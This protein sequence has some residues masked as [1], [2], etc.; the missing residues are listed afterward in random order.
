MRE[1]LDFDLEIREGGPEKYPIS[2]DSPGGQALEEMRFPFD[3]SELKNKLLALENALLRSG[4]SH[5]SISP[6]EQT[7]REFGERLFKAVLTGDVKTRYEVSLREARQQKKGLRLKLR[8]HPPKL[9]LLPWE[10]LYDPDSGEY[11]CF[12]SNTPLVRYVDLRRPVEQLPV[13]PPLKILGMVASPTDLPQLDV[14]K[15]KGHV[16]EALEI[17]RE[18]GLV[19]L[20]WLEEQTWSALL[21]AMWG[22]PWHI[23]HF[24]GHGDFDRNSG[25]GRVAFSDEADRQIVLPARKLARLLDDHPD[26]RLAFLNSCEGAKGGEGDPFSGTAATLVRRGVPAVVA[27]QYEI[28]DKAAIEFSRA[29]YHA[30]ASNLPVDAAVAAARTAVSMYDTL[31]W[32]TPVLYMRSPDGCLFDIKKA[33]GE[34]D[35][36]LRQYR[37]AVET[38]WTSGELHEREVQELEK[39]AHKLGLPPTTAADIEREIMGETKEESLKRRRRAAKEQYRKAVEAVWA[40]DELS[41]AEVEWLGDLASKLGLSTDT[42]AEFERAV[43]GETIQKI[44]RRRREIE[45]LYARARRLHQ[46]REW[47]A[48]IAIFEQIR[49]E[50]PEYRDRE[51]FLQSAHKALELERTVATLYDRGQRHIEAEEWQDASDCLKEVQ[52][53]QPGYRDTETLLPWV[54]KKLASPPTV[55][56]PDLSGQKVSQASSTLASEGLELGTQNRVSH[57]TIPS[58]KI[59]EQDP[60]AGRKL[61]AGSLVSITV[62][63]G[64]RYRWW[65]FALRGLVMVMFGLLIAFFNMVPDELLLYGATAM[66]YGA[67]LM[68]DGILAI[69]DTRRGSGDRSLLR[70]EGRISGLAGLATFVVGLA[71]S[72][73]AYIGVSPGDIVFFIVAFWAI[74]IGIIRMFAAIRLG[75]EFKI[76]RLMVLSGALL[77]VFGIFLLFKLW[78]PRWLLGIWPLASGVLLLTFTSQARDRE[79]S[80]T[81]S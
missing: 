40:D 61:K 52:R 34:E 62:S 20:T 59:I 27:M 5:R 12:S 15:E 57:E 79:R 75:W 9:A 76:V 58:G 31:E 18:K 53:L 38:F 23:F 56:V 67:L 55:E 66:V 54:E 39:I 13:T 29:F 3:A 8:I 78:D 32:G 26:L 7:V 37:K 63:S 80:E 45:E 36:P 4:G 64:P 48:V 2:V 70:V 43:M 74:C 60:A 50:D 30:V 33:G 24:V 17:L 10:F 35:A 11:L 14:E 73:L 42:A 65:A 6:D 71:S 72:W 25:E 21:E 51:S 22:G 81:V 41:D 1:Y 47:Q 16:E 46:N 49:L 77:V 28:T 69:I 19:E 44:V 68:T